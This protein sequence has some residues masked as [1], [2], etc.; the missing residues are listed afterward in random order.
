M[1]RYLL[2]F[3]LDAGA[4]ICLWSANDAA[5]QRYGYPVDLRDLP[6][7]ASLR[8]RG[9]T[10]MRRYDAGFDWNDP[11]NSAPLSSAEHDL[12]HATVNAW[13]DDLRRELGPAYAVVDGTQASLPC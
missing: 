1:T 3:A 11:G 5:R 13:L 7:S 6:I 4:G 2:R 8:W 12:F 9:E 10:L